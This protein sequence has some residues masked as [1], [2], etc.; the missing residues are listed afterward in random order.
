MIFDTELEFENH[1]RKII[2]YRITSKY[3]DIIVLK[4]KTIG[5]IVIMRNG[6]SPA[7]FFVEVKYYQ[8][9]SGRLG[10]GD[11]FGKGMQPEILRKRPAYMESN[12]RWIIG[13]DTHDGAGYWFICSDTVA[14]FIS[15]ESIGKKQNNIREKLLQEHPSIDEDQLV[16]QMMR[17]LVST[18]RL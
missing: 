12:L 8:K 4:S 6:P 9:S 13:S 3:P 1:L 11:R 16:E 5:D 7:I 15:G 14:K 17:W 2:K 18:D 10:L